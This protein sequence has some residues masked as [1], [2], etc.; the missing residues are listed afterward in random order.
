ME[1]SKSTGPGPVQPPQLK[2][3]K[4]PGVGTRPDEAS[5][6]P[7]G[8]GTPQSMRLPRPQDVAPGGARGPLGRGRCP[9]TGGGLPGSSHA[10]D[11]ESVPS[12]TRPPSGKGNHG[13]Q[14]SGV[15]A[16]GQLPE[17]RP[18]SLAASRTLRG[19]HL[20]LT[21]SAQPR[22]PGPRGQTRARLPGARR[23]HFCPRDAGPASI[24]FI[25]SHP[26]S[27]STQTAVASRN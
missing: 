11:R 4:L 7:R 20:A 9:Q 16:G 12:A 8:P 27:P 22:L 13:G 10:T 18:P 3:G 17:A 21:T 2:P 15:D 24:L 26:A 23:S 25:Y 5:E 6:P 1:S 14:G 19:A